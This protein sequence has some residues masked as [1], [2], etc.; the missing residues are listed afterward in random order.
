M[1]LRMGLSVT[2]HRKPR[3][4][5]KLAVDLDRG[6]HWFGSQDTENPERD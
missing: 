3:T 2:G 1:M 4:G 6:G 5:L